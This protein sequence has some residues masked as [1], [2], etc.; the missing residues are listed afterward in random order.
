MNIHSSAKTIGMIKKA[1]GEIISEAKIK[2][3]YNSFKDYRE[4]VEIKSRSARS[5]TS[6][7]LKLL[8]ESRLQSVKIGD[9]QCKN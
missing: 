3:W 1:F 8:N 2:F 5:S 9:W 7:H 4:S 6:E